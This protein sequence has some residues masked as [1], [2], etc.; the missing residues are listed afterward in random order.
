MLQVYVS[1]A[2]CAAFAFGV[3]PALTIATG[4][5]GLAKFWLMP[6]LGVRIVTLLLAAL[7]TLD[8]RAWLTHVLLWCYYSMHSPMC[9]LCGGAAIALYCVLPFRLL[10]EHA[11]AYHVLCIST[12]AVM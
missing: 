8:R 9:Q 11:V 7:K 1:W 4:W 10:W 5:A 2:A 6:W 12:C 3:L